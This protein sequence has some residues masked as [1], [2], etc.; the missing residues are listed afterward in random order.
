MQRARVGLISILSLG[1]IL[2]ASAFSNPRPM[3]AISLTEGRTYDQ[4]HE[5]GY[6]DWSGP[7]QYIYLE[8]RDNSW[9]PPEEGE[10]F[11]GNGCI[12]QITRISSGGSVSG[13]FGSSVGYFE[14]NLA[15]THDDTAGHAVVQACSASVGF[16]AY[17]GPGKGL[18]GFVSM[19]VAVP[20]GCTTWSVSVSGGYVDFRTT[21]VSYSTPPPMPT[22][23]VSPLPTLTSTASFTPTLTLTS[24]ETETFTSTPTLTPTST[25]TATATPTLTPTYTPTST[26][27]NTPSPTPTPLPPEITGQVICDLWGDSGWCRGNESLSLIASDP[28]GYSVSISGELNGDPF[29]CADNCSPPLPEGPGTANYTVTSS[30]GRTADGSSTWQRDSTPPLL[31]MIVPPVDGKNGWH[32]TPVDVNADASDSISGLYSVQGRNNKGVSWTPLPIHLGDGIHSVAV[33]AR[34]VAGNETMTVEIIYVDTVPPLSTFTS[35]SKGSLVQGKV[36]LTGK[37]EDE[38]SG[39][40]GGEI[41]LNEGT[42]WQSVSMNGGGDWSFAW[43]TGNLPYGPYTLLMRA[44]DK[45]GN[46]GGVAQITLLVDNFPPSVSLT[47]RWWIWESGKLQVSPNYFPIASVKMIISD[48]GD[49]WPAAVFHFDPD[50]VPDSVTW[51]RRFA[52]ETLAPPGDYRVTV[53]ACDIYDLCGSATGIIAIP[54]GATATVILTPSP[55]ATFTITPQATAMATARPAT[56]MPRVIKPLPGVIPAPVR[57]THPLPLWQMLGLLGLFLAISSASIVDPRPA[58][59]DRLGEIIHQILNQNILDSSKDDECFSNRK[60]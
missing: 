48:P 23:T 54:V 51:N 13:S 44:T 59:L 10:G 14:V 30:S 3:D 33:R 17:V 43:D 21:D 53:H 6:I 26:P 22:N 47:D 19:P 56:P 31:N 2:M 41:S 9:L 36:T 60:D 20:A 40:A 8:H 28:Q 5:S 12:E 15:M 46:L 38:T 57:P 42:T 35:P 4:A 1:L 29:T 39:P 50:K 7:I 52:D 24:T 37:S 11:C 55:T 45:A 27:T 25:F 16:D 18:P 49:R 32:I 34:D 58:A